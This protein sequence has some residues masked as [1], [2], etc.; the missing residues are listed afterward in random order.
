VEGFDLNAINDRRSANA[1]TLEADLVSKIAQLDVGALL[2]PGAQG[3]GVSQGQSQGTGQQLG[4]GQPQPQSQG[5]RPAGPSDINTSNVG[6]DLANQVAAGNRPSVGTGDINTSNV[7]ADLA[8]QVAGFGTTAGVQNQTLGQSPAAAAQPVPQAQAAEARPSGQ[9]QGPAG[10]SD[11]NTSNIAGDLANQLAPVPGAVPGVT[12]QR[13]A[14]SDI[15]GEIANQLAGGAA[16]VSQG[17]VAAQSGGAG[18]AV[19]EIRSTIIQEANGQQFATQVIQQAGQGQQA[20]AAPAAT[21]A[22]VATASQAPAPPAEAKSTEAPAAMPVPSEALST[23]TAAAEAAP[24]PEAQPTQP[25]A[26]GISANVSEQRSN[27]EVT[28]T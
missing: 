8:N 17:Q 28:L 18:A 9:V 27:S 22:P 6:A 2:N 25:P 13:P 21:E 26:E 20:A 5:L 16:P 4:Q 12:G 3:Q 11:I 1:N 23:S 19:I 24:R 14:S 10:P 7:G 15:A